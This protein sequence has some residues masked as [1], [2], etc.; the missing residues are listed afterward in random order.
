MA[1]ALSTFEDYNIKGIAIVALADNENLTGYWHMDLGNKITAETE[2]RFD[3]L[4]EFNN[5]A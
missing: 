2:I 1:K 4:D 3:V 5:G